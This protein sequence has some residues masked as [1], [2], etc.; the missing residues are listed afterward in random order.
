VGKRF[1]RW[2][3]VAGIRAGRSVR[4][5]NITGMRKALLLLGSTFLLWQLV[6]LRQTTTAEQKFADIFASVLI[7]EHPDTGNWETPGTYIQASADRHDPSGAAAVIEFRPFG[8][9]KPQP[10][11]M[12]R[13]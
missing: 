3:A 6:C 11:C 7:G 10:L 12:I 1:V 4:K 13:R 8:R 2:R 5:V 9:E